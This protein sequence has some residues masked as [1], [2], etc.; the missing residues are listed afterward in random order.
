MNYL[1]SVINGTREKRLDLLYLPAVIAIILVVYGMFFVENNA[2]KLNLQQE[3]AQVHQ[4]LD[5][6]R[7]DFESNVN[8]GIQLAQGVVATLAIEPDMDQARY[9][10]LSS[11]L[12][13]D[14]PQVINIAAAPDLV[15]TLVY[16]ELGNQSVIG[17]DYTK[18]D[19]QIGAVQL[20]KDTRSI[21]F[22]GPVDLV[23]GGKGF[24]ARIPV[25][26]NAKTVS[27]QFWGMVSLVL[28]AQILFTQSGIGPE[29]GLELTLLKTGTQSLPIFKNVSGELINPVTVQINLPHATYVLS[30]TPAG[31]W[32]DGTPNL[33]Q[34]RFLSLLAGLL[35]IFPIAGAGWLLGERQKTTQQ[36]RSSAE[37]LQQ[38]SN[39]LELALSTSQIGVWEFDSAT[40]E[41]FWDERMCEM[42][43]VPKGK[44][45]AYE[46]WVKRL[47]PDDL[48]SA[49]KDF[50]LALVEQN[51]YQSQFRLVKQDGSIIH[52]RTIGSTM[53]N[54]EGFVR[55]LGV[56]WDIT[57]D[58]EKNAQLEN[59]KILAEARNTELEE[60]KVRIE[61][62]ALHDSLTGL[63]NRRYLDEVLAGRHEEAF[64]TL[65]FCSLLHID[66][67]WFKQ[68]ND[69][70]GHAAGDE[71]L[72]HAANIL[73]RN[74]RTAD[75]VARV[76]GDEF[77]ILCTSRL[78]NPLLARLA[79]R[80][81]EEMRRPLLINMRESRC[82]VSIGIASKEAAD[83]NSDQLL[84]NADIALYH[85]KKE[86][87][88][89]FRFYTKQLHQAAV[90]TKCV[91]DEI[92]S[93]IEQEQFIV[94]YQG[95]FDAK[96]LQISGVEALVRWEHPTRGLL[97]PH[98]FLEI[99]EELNV[100][101]TIDALVLAQ[102]L[103]QMD[104][105]KHAGLNV[106]RVSVNISARRLS[107][108]KLIDGL[109]ELNI[110]PGTLTFEFLET[111]LLD[112]SSDQVAWN[113]DQIR[114]LGI[115][116]ELDDFGT[117]YASIVS[118]M[119]LRP[120]ML[121]IDRQLVMPITQSIAQR[122]LVHSI[123]NIGSALGI[124]CVAEGVETM[125][126]ARIMAELGCKTL[127][128]FGLAR[129]MD[130][131]AFAKFVRETEK[132]PLLVA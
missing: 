9:S 17:L 57:E 49:K 14:L 37:K 118:L 92:L 19:A 42:Y 27:E 85:A 86:G 7:A 35:V 82:S 55:I 48:E 51:I 93:G 62:N 24:I 45:P 40:E 38:I 96:T 3:Q 75:F 34:N 102:A 97:G 80:I 127:Q 47:H 56:N 89:T 94:H 26:Q 103:K 110:T 91:A 88:N 29:N 112:S 108:E 66:L 126:H 54:E 18:V 12:F 43:D 122:E 8:S 111:I 50:S 115:D 130:G 60:A 98:E 13:A 129:P 114:E 44:K 113:I 128:G 58:V 61:H 11:Q 59:A 2:R 69:T 87:R 41:L 25:F 95:Q 74:V 46:D 131:Q 99:S 33:W 79:T 84:I 119:K 65:E 100:M 72:V 132:N 23:Q 31:G 106:P 30:A 10:A 90:N 78:E 36:L 117:G 104:A 121:K 70:L 124:G 81:N 21:V 20:A 6:I 32:S 109:K 4:Q 71:M 77:V 83:A 73:N 63:P 105:W 52:I 125:E 67:D 123:V 107:D 1:S 116:I 53:M 64:G 68:I 22:E 101:A 16:P 120:K 28:D 76:G 15:V 5:E 39:R